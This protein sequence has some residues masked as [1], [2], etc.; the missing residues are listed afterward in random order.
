LS[1][2][3]N[4]EGEFTLPLVATGS[5]TIEVEAKGFETYKVELVDVNSEDLASV[6]VTLTSAPV[7]A[8]VGLL[9][10]DTPLI[11]TQGGTTT[12]DGQILRNLPRPN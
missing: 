4:D 11:E 9:M 7:T 3:T 8:V 12:I 5:Y 2:S 10:V 1:T 6:E